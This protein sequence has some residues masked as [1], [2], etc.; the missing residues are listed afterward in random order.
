MRVLLSLVLGASAVLAQEDS[1]VIL[2]QTFAK[3]AQG[4]MVMGQ[5]GGV[6]V[7]GG[8]LAIRY[9]LDAKQFGPAVVPVPSGLAGMRQIRFRVK[10]DHDTAIALLLIEKKPGGGNYTAMFWAP[11]NAWQQIEL[12]PADFAIGEGPS[13]PVDADGKLDLDQVT[14]IG[15]VDLAGFFN[16][17]DMGANSP[18]VVARTTGTH[19]LQLSGFEVMRSGAERKSTTRIDG[20]DRGFLQ[21]FTLGGMDLKLATEGSPLGAPALQASYEPA[22]GSIE[23]VSRSTAGIDLSQAKRIAFDVASEREITLA[24]SLELTKPGSSQGPRYMLTVFPPA[25]RKPFHV[26][27]RLADFDHDE[28]SPDGPVRLDPARIKSIAFVDISAMMG[29]Q[30][31]SNKFWISK[32]EALR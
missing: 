29:G 11:A 9:D 6:S 31:G 28:N 1:G 26:D 8:A 22:E 12:T 18:L 16:H 4:W 13:D 23:V 20:F 32:L 3:D 24:I 5:G 15:L 25:G 19:S 10:A 30:I 7:S 27:V 17:L 14:A 21:W 2:R